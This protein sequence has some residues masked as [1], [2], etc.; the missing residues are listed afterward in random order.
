MV[1]VI[2]LKT[3][4][5]ASET[6][7]TSM[8][9]TQLNNHDRSAPLH[10]ATFD[11]LMRSG[12]NHEDGQKKSESMTET[13]P[14]RHRIWLAKRIVTNCNQQDGHM[15]LYGIYIYIYTTSTHWAVWCCL[16]A[17]VWHVINKLCTA[18]PAW[19]HLSARWKNMKGL[20]HAGHN[21]P[22]VSFGFFEF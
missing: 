10:T 16:A 12:E 17:R 9:H 11:A 22:L 13:T 14:Q 20:V 3:V 4:G 1:I 5:V 7:W 8:I 18:R 19:D 2:F 21:R 15:I 6:L